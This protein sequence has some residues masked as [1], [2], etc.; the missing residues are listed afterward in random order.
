MINY[1]FVFMAYTDAVCLNVQISYRGY[2]YWRSVSQRLDKCHCKVE[3]HLAT[4]FI[5]KCPDLDSH[6]TAV[7]L[8]SCQETDSSTHLE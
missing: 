1:I 2:R 7:A 3:P 5:V 6:V 4:K 8:T